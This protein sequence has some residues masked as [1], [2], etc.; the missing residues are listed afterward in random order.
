MSVFKLRVS[1]H[2]LAGSV[3]ATKSDY[4]SSG[5]EQDWN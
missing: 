1:N 5:D 2:L 3:E 4:S